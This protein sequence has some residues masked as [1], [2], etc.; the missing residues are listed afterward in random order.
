L[1]LGGLGFIG[2]ALGRELIRRG[3]AIRIYD[4]GDF[5]PLRHQGL[6]AAELIKG[7]FLDSE[8][9]TPALRGCDYVFH[10]IGTTLPGSAADNPTYD[11]ETNVL[12]T[13]RLLELLRRAPPRRL[14][15]ASSGGTVYGSAQMLPIPEHHPTEPRTPYGVT[16]LMIEKYLSV[17]R[18]LH[19]LPFRVYRFSNPY[20]PGQRQKQQGVIT[21]FLRCLRDRQTLQIWGDG[22]VVRDYL[23]IEDLARAVADSFELSAS[24][25]TF[26]C[27]SGQGTSLREIVTLL[28]QATGRKPAVE[29]T[30]GRSIDVP[31]NVLDITALTELCS[32]R[33]QVSLP[34][35]I[36]RTWQTI[37]AE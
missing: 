19:G 21:T 16:K 10:L 14:V 7:D 29:Y 2:S 30:P 26:N 33:P 17:Y 22:S 6:E 25:N 32:W 11:V 20:G 35:G 8:S 36:Q 9:L 27:G 3:H 13:L 34:E 37:L 24:P 5:H 1:I 12:G 23:Y 31:A 4:L 18:L 15:F 28:E